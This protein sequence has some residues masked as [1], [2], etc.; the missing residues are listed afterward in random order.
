MSG[1]CRVGQEAAGWA[2]SLEHWAEGRSG[3]PPNGNARR[4]PQQPGF[5]ALAVC[6]RERSQ[7]RKSMSPT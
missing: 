7:R 5:L 4:F 3:S 1:G 2:R 6:P